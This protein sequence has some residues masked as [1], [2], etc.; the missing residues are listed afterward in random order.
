MSERQNTVIRKELHMYIKLYLSPQEKEQLE[1]IAESRGISLSKLCHEQI[2]PLLSDHQE[3]PPETQSTKDSLKLDSCVK[4][5]FTDKEYHELLTASN[6]LPLSRFI[7]REYLSRRE[8]IVI[9][10][11]T[12]DISALAVKVSSYIEQ[13]NNFIAA[14][15]L[16]QQL[17]EADYQR[18]LQIANDTQTAL[19]EVATYTKNNRKSIRASGVRILRK[20]IRHAAQQLIHGKEVTANDRHL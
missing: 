9:S 15:A 5:Y 2:T 16:R 14:L 8:P 11:Y 13:L 1:T 10:V 7:R 12:D 17:Y 3:L 19:K 4:V 20:E 18:L 6:G